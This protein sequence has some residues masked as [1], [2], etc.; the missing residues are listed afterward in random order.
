MSTKVEA[1]LDSIVESAR[2]AF[3][4][5]LLH[6]FKEA[7]HDI[8]VE[9]WTLMLHL[10]QK[11]GQTQQE[12]SGCSKKDNPSVCRLIDNMEKRNLVLRVPDQNDRRINRIYLTNKGKA[13]QE[14]LINIAQN[15]LKSSTKTISSTD[16]KTC[17]TVL[18]KMIENLTA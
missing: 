10:W 1:P 12:I 14:E 9:Q 11:E 18:E 8:T 2:T 4:R 7:G 17:K 16:L 6:K 13:L 5:S 3:Y 15:N